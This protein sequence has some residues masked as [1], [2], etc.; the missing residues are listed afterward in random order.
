M[1]TVQQ[2]LNHTS[3]PLDEWD[4]PLTLHLLSI[5]KHQD[6][7]SEKAKPK[8]HDWWWHTDYIHVLHGAKKQK[9]N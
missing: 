9:Q 4:L 5:S 2:H 7:D 1:H 6:R 8:I 3:L